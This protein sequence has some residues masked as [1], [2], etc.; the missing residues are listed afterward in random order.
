VPVPAVAAQLGIRVGNADS[1]AGAE[2][3]TIGCLLF[4]AR[5]LEQLEGKNYRGLETDTLAQSLETQE[6][7]GDR[8]SSPS[9]DGLLQMHALGWA[10]DVPRKTLSKDAV[11]DLSFILTDLRFAGV[12]AFAEEDK[13]KAFHVVRH[14]AYASKF[15]QIYW[16][17]VGIPAPVKSIA[18]SLQ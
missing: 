4:V 18:G 9:T 1:P 3:S 2:R 14:P 8:K 10:F 12:L 16:D 5:Q 7:S 11:R 17:A 15:E 13:P 6:G